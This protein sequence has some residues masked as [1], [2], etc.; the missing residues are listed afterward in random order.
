MNDC[1]GE[2]RDQEMATEK[3]ENEGGRIAAEVTHDQRHEPVG[4]P[5]TDRLT[6]SERTD[7]GNRVQYWTELPRHVTY[8]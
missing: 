5:R 3:W 4:L 1:I 6:C 8:H 7:F 2:M